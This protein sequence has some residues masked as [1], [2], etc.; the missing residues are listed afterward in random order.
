ME[1]EEHRKEGSRKRGW[2]R[3]HGTFSWRFVWLFTHCSLVFYLHDTLSVCGVIWAA[4]AVYIARN[5]TFFEITT[6]L[7]DSTHAVMCFSSFAQVMQEFV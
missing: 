5:H 1:R 7:I 2:F 4:F 3:V 6:I